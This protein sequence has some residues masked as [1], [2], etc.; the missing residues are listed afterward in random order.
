MKDKRRFDVVPFQLGRVACGVNALIEVLQLPTQKLIF[1][2]ADSNV[3]GAI[4]QIAEYK[5]P[6][7]TAVGTLNLQLQQLI[8]NMIIDTRTLE[9]FKSLLERNLEHLNKSEL[10]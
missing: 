4:V 9:L 2:P 5:L 10:L 6:F 8:D 1:P 7:S 3:A